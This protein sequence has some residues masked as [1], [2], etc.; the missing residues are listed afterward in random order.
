MAIGLRPGGHRTRGLGM[1]IGTKAADGAE[2]RPRE[3][4]DRI[5]AT[6]QGSLPIGSKSPAKAAAQSDQGHPPRPP[7]NRIKAPRQGR[8]RSKAPGWNWLS[9]RSLAGRGLSVSRDFLEALL[10]S[11]PLELRAS[12]PEA[13]GTPTPWRAWR[14]GQAPPSPTPAH[15]PE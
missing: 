2:N 12:K 7:P 11:E 5:K 9:G 3:P 8:R 1:T 14:E 10:I 13:P 15:R 6:S 4:P